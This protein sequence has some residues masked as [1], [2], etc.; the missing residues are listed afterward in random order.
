VYKI[1]SFAIAFALA[2]FTP[3]S[4]SAVKL[5]SSNDK[6]LS[7][8]KSNTSIRDG[9]RVW[10]RP[11]PT[12]IGDSF[13]PHYTPKG[14][15]VE[16]KEAEISN[17]CQ[18][19]ECYLFSVINFINVFNKNQKNLDAPIVSEEF[20]AAHKFLEHI[21]EAMQLGI[22]DPML[23]HDLEGGFAYEAIHL[24]RTVG[25]V[26]KDAWTPKKKL[27]QWDTTKIYRVLK[28]RVPEIHKE[29]KL[30]VEKHGSWEA[31]EV[32][33]AQ[34]KG[35]DE[36]KEVILDM[37]GD[38]PTQFEFKGENFTPLSF[39]RR[40]GFPRLSQFFINN[41]GEYAIPTN[42]K[43]VLRETFSQHGGKF[44][45]KDLS[46]SRII[47]NMQIAID[48]GLP[49]IID[50]KWQDD[51]HTMVAVGYEVSENNT[52]VRYKLMNSWDNT[53]GNNGHAWYTIEDILKNITGTY[54]ID[55]LGN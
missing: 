36:L 38:L 35:Y 17:Q 20:L 29:L 32:K 50:L 19:S 45:V 9:R 4:L 6:C 43:K 31:I 15:V 39:E 28:K 48:R 3:F 5:P 1:L 51:G 41:S 42:Y 23:I 10:V 13:E 46:P 21:K 8:Y 54:S 37:T 18:T 47:S 7:V 52:V 25:L 12:A 44:R 49:V 14:R 2:T 26:P 11:E 27:G 16:L 33:E 30:L 40:F 55:K 34:Q 24:T 22:E 53:F